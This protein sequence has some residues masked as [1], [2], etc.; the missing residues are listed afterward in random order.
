LDIREF[1][2][3][4]RVDG[5]SSNEPVR[6]LSPTP[7]LYETKPLP[8]MTMPDPVEL[9]TGWCAPFISNK[10]SLQQIV[11]AIMSRIIF[12]SAVFSYWY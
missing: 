11:A 5:I 1:C 2:Y 10:H 12:L 7:S 9:Y 8:K 3:L 6:E 4:K